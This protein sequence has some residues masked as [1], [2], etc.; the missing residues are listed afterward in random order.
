MSRKE[1]QS[2]P[3]GDPQCIATELLKRFDLTDEIREQLMQELTYMAASVQGYEAGIVLQPLPSKTEA[4]KQLKQLSRALVRIRSIME[5]SDRH[6]FNA[7]NRPLY[8]G[9][10]PSL[11]EACTHAGHFKT[12]QHQGIGEIV[13][14]LCGQ[15]DKHIQ[16]IDLPSS[17]AG[18][19]D[20]LTRLLA[21]V[22]GRVYTRATGDRPTIRTSW[23]DSKAYGPFYDFVNSAI[24]RLGIDISAEYIARKA[25]DPDTYKKEIELIR[26]I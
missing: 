22:L 5:T 11:D 1:K 19:D 17:K 4:E 13:Y 15:L 18:R 16:A 9:E 2:A 25:T 6:I 3:S 26:S 14:S 20:N 8:E 21:T 24:K 12:S 10:I 23:E 7:I